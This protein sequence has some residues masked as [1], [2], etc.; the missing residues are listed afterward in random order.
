MDA[1][2]DDR[3]FAVTPAGGDPVADE[4]HLREAA[5]RGEAFKAAVDDGLTVEVA[6]RTAGIDVAAAQ[7]LV[8][9]GDW[10]STRA[11]NGDAV[12]PRFLFAP[13]GGELPGIRAAW[14]RAKDSGWSIYAL[15]SFLTLPQPFFGGQCAHSWLAAGNDPDQ[16]VD[17]IGPQV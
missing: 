8:D 2:G 6:A 10:P 12:I 4:N 5:R 16:V 1:M 15:A 9:A 17:L 3:R 13:A 14:A 11:G 7:R